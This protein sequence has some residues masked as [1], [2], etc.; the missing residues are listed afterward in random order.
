MR[1]GMGIENKQHEWDCPKPEK[2]NQVDKNTV[3][4]ILTG[5]LQRCKQLNI[6]GN[7]MVFHKE[8]HHAIFCVLSTFIRLSIRNSHIKSQYSHGRK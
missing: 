2:G 1:S 7:R 3:E 4:R 6:K 8:N 5:L